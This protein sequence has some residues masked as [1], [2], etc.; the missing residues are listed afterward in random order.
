MKLEGL[1]DVNELPEWGD[2]KNKLQEIG[3]T[4]E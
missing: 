4:H 3:K 2:L 1:I